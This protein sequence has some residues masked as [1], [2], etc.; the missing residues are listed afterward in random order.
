M[1]KMKIRR[2]GAYRRN[3]SRLCSKVLSAVH[4]YEPV[5]V[6]EADAA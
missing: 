4:R 5:G 2:S 6:V 1:S 3:L